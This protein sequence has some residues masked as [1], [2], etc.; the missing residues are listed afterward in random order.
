MSRK[1]ADLK[2][3]FLAMSED[4]LLEKVT[5]I[6]E[7]RKISKHA[8]PKSVKKKQDKKKKVLD[9]FE[10]LTPEEKAKMIAELGG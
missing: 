8:P 9:L 4:E 7:D 1:L 6:R 3:H 10:A 2:K 5:E